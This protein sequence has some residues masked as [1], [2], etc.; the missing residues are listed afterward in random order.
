MSKSDMTARPTPYI[1]PLTVPYVKNFNIE[2]V[3]DSP[4][5]ITCIVFS[6]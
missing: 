5:K 3:L 1:F 6:T 4:P 2:C